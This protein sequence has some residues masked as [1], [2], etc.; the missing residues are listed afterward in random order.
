MAANIK[1]VALKAGVSIATVSLVL[2][3]NARI[4]SETKRKVLKAVKE[5]DYHPSRSARGLVSNITGNIGFILTNDHFLKT[6]PFYTRIFLGSEFAARESEYYILLA[7]ID[8]NFNEG[9]SLPRFLKE[10]NVDGIII[11]GK[12]PSEFIRVV[13]KLEI[14]LVFVDFFPQQG[15]FPVVIIDNVKGGFTA[16]Q[17]LINLGHTK[18]GFIGADISHPSISD[19]LYGYKSAMQNS[20]LFFDAGFIVIDEDYPN[21]AYGYSAAKKLYAIRPDITAIFA[22]ND[23]MAIGAMH[24]LKDNGLKIPDDISLIGFDDVEADLM[25]DP[26]LS[27]IHVPKIELGTEALNLLMNVIKSNAGPKKILVPIELVVRESTKKIN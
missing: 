1:D 24:F 25:L 14:P 9:D 21:R 7:T 8:S 5:L 27:T 13:S 23:A 6:E 26:P 20:N 15:D 18:I 22:C 11:A 4:S 19:R 17:H 16:V 10:K 2:N 12:V 3:N